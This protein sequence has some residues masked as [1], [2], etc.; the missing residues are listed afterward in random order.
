MLTRRAFLKSGGLAMLA[1]TF[2]GAPL[3][4]SRTALAA[5]VSSNSRRKI[6]VAIFQRGAMDG[7]MAV[8]LFN[9]PKYQELRRQLAMS[10]SKSTDGNFLIDLDERFG[11]HP[12]FSSIYNFYK[13]GRLAIVHG[14][15]SPDPTR[16]HFDA[17]DYMETGTPGRKGT[18]S[19]WLNRAE[20]LLGHE[21]AT[22]F[23]AVSM[24]AALPRSLYGDEPALAISD[25][26]DFG[27][28]LNYNNTMGEGTAEGFEALYKKTT[29]EILHGT[30]RESFEAVKILKNINVKNYIPSNG[31]AYPDSPLG[32]NLMQIAQLIKSGVG[33]EIAFAETGGWDT[34]FGEG[35]YNG[36]FARRAQ[37]LSDSVS[38][39][40]TDL[41]TLQDDVV[42]MTM[43][44]FGRTVRE[45]GSGGT[46]H[47][48]A[49]CLFVLG[50]NVAGGK[51]HGKIESLDPDAL[52][53][54][55][56]LPV[57][58]DFRSVFSEV[59]G[60]HLNISNDAVLFPGWGGK[61]MKFM[62]V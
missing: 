53:D 13:E 45:N 8:P 39:F 32:K 10:P 43:T 61:R 38:A 19:G 22:P 6:L 55:R 23:R 34:H 2:G 31:A 24:T 14:V 29:Q 9:D 56:D 5:E 48:R 40:W 44:E 27:L 41:G 18:A 57:T 12:S 51:V 3:F 7:L 42:L 62:K 37:D 1:A 52:D 33:L 46:D 11:L 30:G 15:G 4:L 47:G 35:T 21:A 60:T 26:K 54:G 58:T 20:G 16:S 25:L 17:Q 59:A 50:N 49:S 28:N 36:T